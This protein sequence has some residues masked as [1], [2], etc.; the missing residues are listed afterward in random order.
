MQYCKASYLAMWMTSYSVEK[1]L[2][3]DNVVKSLKQKFKVS[4]EGG[5][6]ST[7]LGL[8]IDQNANYIIISQKQGNNI[9]P[10]TIPDDVTM[11]DPLDKI[12]QRD[13]KPLAGKLNWISTHSRP[14]IAYDVCQTNNSTGQAT[15]KGL[16][17][18]N[19]ALKK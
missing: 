4:A 3:M 11:T 12:Q 17:N 10:I 7:Y 13:L 6:R 15:V 1:V 19:K 9:K 14:D 2:F 16:V 18:A 8:Q 5:D